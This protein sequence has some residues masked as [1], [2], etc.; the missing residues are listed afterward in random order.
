[1]FPPMGVLIYFAILSNSYHNQI[2]VAKFIED[3]SEI[4]YEKLLLSLELDIL[5]SMAFLEHIGILFVPF[6]C[7]FLSFFAM[8]IIGDA[9]G[10]RYAVWTPLLTCV[11]L[12][13]VYIVVKYFKLLDGNIEKDLN[14]LEPNILVNHERSS[15]RN[16]NNDEEV[17]EIEV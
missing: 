14:N 12:L 2:L 11:I 9:F 1:V 15:F 3:C 17:G 10:W 5:E 6:T 7:L 4:K 16:A 8:D 13:V